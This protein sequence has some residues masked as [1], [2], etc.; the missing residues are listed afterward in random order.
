MGDERQRNE[1]TVGKILDSKHTNWI[2]ISVVSIFLAFQ[3]ETNP[4][5]GEYFL[6]L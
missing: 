6:L 2:L 5:N 1:E 3:V 4:V